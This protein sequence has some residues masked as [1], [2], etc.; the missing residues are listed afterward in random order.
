MLTEEELLLVN[1]VRVRI[2]KRDEVEQPVKGGAKGGK[3]PP[4]KAAAKDDKGKGKAAI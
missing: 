2:R 4:P 1:E 3:A